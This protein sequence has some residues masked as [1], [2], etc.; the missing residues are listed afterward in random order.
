MVNARHEARSATLAMKK[1]FAA[2]VCDLTHFFLHSANWKRKKSQPHAT[3][4]GA[5]RYAIHSN[6]FLSSTLQLCPSASAPLVWPIVY[7]YMLYFEMQCV[8]LCAVHL[9]FCLQFVRTT[10]LVF[11][12]CKLKVVTV[13]ASFMAQADNV[14][15]TH[16]IISRWNEWTIRH[17][18]FSSFRNRNAFIFNAHSNNSTV[19][20]LELQAVDQIQHNR[21]IFGGSKIDFIFV[22]DPLGLPLSFEIMLYHSQSQSHMWLQNSDYIL[23]S[24]HI[25]SAHSFFVWGGNLK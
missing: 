18:F 14:V 10:G 3:H 5:C 6:F 16:F 2:A 12:L 22:F 20:P 9:S 1:V 13:V 11:M 21:W 19:F 24:D 17:V 23:S 15:R 8:C 25:I 4:I 7:N